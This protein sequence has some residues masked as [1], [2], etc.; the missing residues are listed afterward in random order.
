MKAAG[1]KNSEKLLIIT[2]RELAKFYIEN[3]QNH[4]EHSEKYLKE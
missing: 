2:S 1:R 4:F 3:W